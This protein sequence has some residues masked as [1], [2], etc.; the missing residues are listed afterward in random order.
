MSLLSKIPGMRIVARLFEY[1][2]R[3]APLEEFENYDAYWADRAVDEGTTRSLDRFKV[4]SE[5]LDLDDSVLDIGCGDAS[6]QQY[7]ARVKPGCKSMG[8]DAS[9]EAVRVAQE[10]GCT[11]QVI[12]NDLRLVDQVEGRWQ[13][14]TLMEVLEHIPDAE[15][16]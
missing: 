13:V 9:A 7:L 16:L 1:I 4:V 8:L 10:H 14:V 15:N 12:D 3:P 11:A 2:N 6:F 5:L